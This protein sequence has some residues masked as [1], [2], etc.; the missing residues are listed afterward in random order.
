MTRKRATQPAS[1]PSPRV[2]VNVVEEVEFVNPD[3]TPRRS[4]SLERML[5]ETAAHTSRDVVG[6]LQEMAAGPIGS[7]HGHADIQDAISEIEWLRASKPDNVVTRQELSAI[8]E[9]VRSMH[10]ALEALLDRLEAKEG[11]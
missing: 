1:F 3:G 4:A 7:K 10:A 2:V 5:S 9:Q 11:K 6:R 8:T